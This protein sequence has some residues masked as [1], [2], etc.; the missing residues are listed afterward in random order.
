M[1]V[2]TPNDIQ[3]NQADFKALQLAE[4]R[5][6]PSLSKKRFRLLVYLCVDEF[7]TLTINSPAVRVNLL[8]MI[9][10]L[11][12][13]RNQA[14]QN[15]S[16]SAEISTVLGEDGKEEFFSGKEV[17]P[18]DDDFQGRIL[19][20]EAVRERYQHEGVFEKQ[21][22]Y[23]DYLWDHRDCPERWPFKI[24]SR[25]K[26]AINQIS[27]AAEKWIEKPL[28]VRWR[29]RGN[30]REG[31]EEERKRFGEAAKLIRLLFQE[32]SRQ[33]KGVNT[34]VLAY[35]PIEINADRG[36]ND[37]NSPRDIR[38]RV[39]GA[40]KEYLL[41]PV[42]PPVRSVGDH[43]TGHVDENHDADARLKAY[44]EVELTDGMGEL[45]FLWCRLMKKVDEGWIGEIDRLWADFVGG[46]EVTMV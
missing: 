14:V 40:I 26:N 37:G 21:E 25:Q 34:A 35:E 7:A 31:G 45:P 39:F 43:M 1:H 44:M 30:L 11:V 28:D 3:A 46:E 27:R 23:I 6:G 18:D 4:F 29:Y 10:K 19:L 33:R 9:L 2:R 20:A 41:H 15:H 32:D 24:S 5:C 17:N 22:R 36:I 13:A 16:K 8:S 42:F 38:P 12:D